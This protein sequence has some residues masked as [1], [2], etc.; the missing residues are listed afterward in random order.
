MSAKEPH[1][2]PDRPDAYPDPFWGQ[3]HPSVYPRLVNIAL[4]ADFPA[5]R[6]FSNLPTIVERDIRRECDEERARELA[7]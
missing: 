3:H 1:I 4:S 5:M 7:E 2:V 6:V